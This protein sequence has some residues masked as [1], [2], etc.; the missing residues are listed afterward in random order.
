M[1]LLDVV[2]EEDAALKSAR[3]RSKEQSSNDRNVAGQNKFLI[4]IGPVP[5]DAEVNVDAV[6]VVV[7]GDDVV[8][9]EIFSVVA[10]VVLVLLLVTLLVEEVEVVKVVVPTVFDGD[11]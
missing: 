8:V 6:V 10:L 5:L 2:E 3:T 4:I 9:V 11:K 1:L 7:V